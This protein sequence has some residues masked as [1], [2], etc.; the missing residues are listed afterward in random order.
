MNPRT[1]WTAG[2]PQST[3]RYAFDFRPKRWYAGSPSVFAYFGKPGSPLSSYNVSNLFH[4]ARVTKNWWILGLFVPLH[5]YGVILHA[6]NGEFL[7]LDPTRH[8]LDWN[9]A[10]GDPS[11]P[12]P[13]AYPSGIYDVQ[14]LRLNYGH[15]ET[16]LNYI[17]S[18]GYFQWTGNNCLAFVRNLVS[19]LIEG[20]G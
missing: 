18:R 1:D 12:S 6:T 19:Y 2:T 9:L 13:F 15:P 8:A 4:S 17:S 11:G 20:S 5:H 10:K 14:L 16:V 7:S 3:A